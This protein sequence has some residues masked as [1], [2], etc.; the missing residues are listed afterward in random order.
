M[1]SIIKGKFTSSAEYSMRTVG[2]HEE[3]QIVVT[4]FRA[5]LKKMLGTMDLLD[6][7]K[8]MATATYEGQKANIERM[9]VVIEAGIDSV[10]AE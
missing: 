9:T 10:K 4:N 5:A 1:A 7:D 6:A 8:L 2:Q 3:G